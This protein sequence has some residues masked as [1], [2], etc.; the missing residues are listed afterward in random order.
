MV[1]K[2]QRVMN[3]RTYEMCPSLFTLSKTNPFTHT[4]RAFMDYVMCHFYDC[5]MEITFPMFLMTQR[6]V[7]LPFFLLHKILG[8]RHRVTMQKSTTWYR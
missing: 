5:D 2:K 7:L 6:K 8:F 3:T 1:G 4:P